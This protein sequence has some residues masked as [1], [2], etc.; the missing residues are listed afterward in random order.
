MGTCTGSGFTL[1]TSL[2]SSASTSI[3]S[4]GVKG[5]SARNARYNCHL[6]FLCAVPCSVFITFLLCLI[7]SLP[8]ALLP[9]PTSSHRLHEQ[10]PPALH[11]CALSAGWRDATGRLAPG[12]ASA[13]DIVL[14]CDC[15][16]HGCQ[17]FGLGQHQRRM[18]SSECHDLLQSICRAAKSHMNHSHSS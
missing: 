13:E 11:A 12:S 10:P 1:S 2:A 3:R 16:I 6:C 9:W 15:A 4:F 18:C 5:S 8:Q 14:V 17:S 7:C